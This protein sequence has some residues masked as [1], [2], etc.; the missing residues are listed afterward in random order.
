MSNARAANLVELTSGKSIPVETV[1]QGAAKMW[2]SVNQTGTQSVTDSF[3]LS[4][5]VDTGVG[6][7]QFNLSAAMLNNGWALATADSG[8]GNAPLGANSAT[9][10]AVTVSNNAFAGADASRLMATVHGQHA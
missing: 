8:Y 9:S 2:A 1:R 7:T 6:A 10:F 5:I 4:S 3:N